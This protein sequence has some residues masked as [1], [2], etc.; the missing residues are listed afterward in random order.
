MKDHL[1]HLKTI[2]QYLPGPVTPRIKEA[3]VISWEE[4]L[5]L[6]KV[7]IYSNCY[8]TLLMLTNDIRYVYILK[9]LAVRISVVSHVTIIWVVG[10]Y[11]FVA[12]VS[13]CITGYT[14]LCVYKKV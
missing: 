3:G 9:M 13:G 14:D 7:T 10:S 11:L 2:I 12:S 4:F 1:P 8:L 6:G 5:D